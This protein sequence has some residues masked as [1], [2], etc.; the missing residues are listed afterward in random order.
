MLSNGNDVGKLVDLN[1]NKEKLQSKIDT[2]EAEWV[3]LEELIAEYG[4][5]Q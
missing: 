4:D 2:L 1:K 3:G 5:S